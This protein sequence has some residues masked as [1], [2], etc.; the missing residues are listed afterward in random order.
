MVMEV[1]I[2]KKLPLSTLTAEVVIYPQ[3]LKNVRV[4]NKAAAKATRQYR[5][6]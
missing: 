4:A 5:K 1:L 6:Q 3:L 2:D